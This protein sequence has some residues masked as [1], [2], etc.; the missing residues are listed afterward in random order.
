MDVAPSK[1]FSKGETLA[2]M[3]GLAFYASCWVLPIIDSYVGFDGFVEAHKAFWRLL[4]QD[5][6]SDSAATVLEVFFISMGWL[7]NEL[8]VVALVAF[9]KWP[10]FSLRCMAFS[11]GIMASWQ[12]ALAQEFPLLIGYW[13]W[14]AA[15][16][17]MLVLFARRLSARSGRD[18]SS[19]I[20]DPVTLTLLV[21]PLANAALAMLTGMDL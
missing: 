6:A 8:F 4:T 19:I 13:L 2:F 7:A 18:L 15:A 20:A 16:A 14:V 11:L 17:I 5:G 10:L 9:L 1:I 3:V 12:I 21:V